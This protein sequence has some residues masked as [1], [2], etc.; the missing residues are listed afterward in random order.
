MD[1]EG[2]WGLNGFGWTSSADW[3]R[4]NLMVGSKKRVK[5]L[6]KDLEE[7]WLVCWNLLYVK[8][9]RFPVTKGRSEIKTIS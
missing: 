1:K 2:E 7:Y 8:H 5:V 6:G 9:G 3:Q 4:D